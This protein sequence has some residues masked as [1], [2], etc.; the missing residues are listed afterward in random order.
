M[1]K[2]SKISDEVQR[3]RFVYGFQKVNELL[4]DLD[5]YDQEPDEQHRLLEVIDLTLLGEYENEKNCG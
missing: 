3:L 2:Y 4:A 1:L 5:F